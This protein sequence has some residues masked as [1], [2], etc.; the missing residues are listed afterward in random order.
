MDYDRAVA[1]AVE[2]D[3][4]GALRHAGVTD[5][6][7]SARRCAEYSTDASLYRVLPSVVVFPRH[8]DDIQAVAEVSRALHVPLTPRG[9][10]TSIAGNAV[11]TGIVLDFSRHLN[12]IH[13]IDAASATAIVQPGVIL[14]DLQRAAAPSGLRFGPDPSTHSRCTVGGMIGNNACGSRALGYGRTVD[15]V[16]ALDILTGTGE[17]LR[18]DATA[19]PATSLTLSALRALVSQ[20]LALI[21]T[22]FGRFNRQVSGY[23]LEHLLPESGFDVA[24]AFVGTEGSWGLIREATLRLVR[25]PTATAL[26][27]LGYPDMVAAAEVVPAILSYRPVALEGL[28]ARIVNVVRQRKGAAAVPALPDGQGWLFVEIGG[29]EPA[30]VYSRAKDVIAAADANDG[31]IV[32]EAKAASALWEIREDGAGLA[33][34]ATDPPGQ[35][36][37][38]DAAVPPESS[39]LPARLRGAHG[40]QR[41]NRRALW[42]FRRRLRAYPHRLS[43]ASPRG[44]PNLPRISHRGS[45]TR[46]QLRR[47]DVWRARRRASARRVTAPDVF[48]RSNRYLRCGQTSL[49]PE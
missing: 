38:E 47:I 46:R 7:G 26:A 14:D 3:V 24:K 35:S 45:P 8:V 39:R 15:N 16:V 9:A 22:E 41:V 42:T 1:R 44:S 29:D 17:L 28:D 27:V 40:R 30:E 48:E 32:T 12:R 6:D 10:G 13:D 21:R 20:R 25:A 34:R 36:G 43:A 4:I 2:N 5:V 37:W 11:G 33:A 49:R 23:S 31:W 19:D 18:L